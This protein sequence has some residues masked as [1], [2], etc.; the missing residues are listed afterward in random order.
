MIA[1]VA[2]VILAGGASSRFGSNK[3]LAAY[4]GRPL[5]SHA[6]AAMEELFASCLLVTNTPETYRFLGW[7]MTSDRFRGAGPL[8]GIHA[9]LAAITEPRAFIS[10][11]DMPFLDARLIRFLCGIKGDWDAVVPWLNG[12]PEPLY[13]V[14]H[15]NCLAVITA[16]LE[17]GEGKIGLIYSQLRLR[18]VTEAE[19]LAVVSDLSTFHNVNRPADLP[20]AT[21]HGE[22]E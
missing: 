20:T 3:A 2:G 13:G 21:G 17:Q 5:I 10:G 9:A 11:C 18:R 8:A 4:Q 7:A 1:N 15:R 14:Y 19:I 12:R 16:N 6:A 22:H